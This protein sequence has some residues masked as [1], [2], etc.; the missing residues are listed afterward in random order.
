MQGEGVPHQLH[1]APVP[2]GCFA[3]QEV[4]RRVGAVH[5]EAKVHRYELAGCVPAEV[6]QDGGEAVDFGV[7]RGEGGR[8]A[9]DEG[10]EELGA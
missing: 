6:V 10:A 1:L 5:L 7:V 9:G 3:A 4:A 2:V 8:L